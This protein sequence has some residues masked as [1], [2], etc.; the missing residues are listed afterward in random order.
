MEHGGDLADAV[1][2]GGGAPSDW[3]D[4]STGINPHAWPVP[5]HLL[6]AG[7]TRLP[8]RTDLSRLL[9]V[10][11]EAYGVPESCAVVA[12]AGTQALIQVLP[13]LAGPGRVAVLGPTYSEHALAWRAAGFA[14]TEVQ[15]L[16]AAGGCTHLVVV[17]PN[18][19]DGRVVSADDLVGAARECRAR[20]G[21]AVVDESFADVRPEVSLVPRLAGEPVVV[22]RSFGKFFG[23]AG[24][25]LGFAIAAPATAERIARALGPWAVS[26]PALGIG[27]AA[28][29]DAGWAQAMRARLAREADRLDS[30]LAGA[31]LRIVGGTSLFRL[32]EVPA[33]E[34]TAADIHEGLARARI[35]VRRFPERPSLLRFGLPPDRAGLDR[36]AAA[37]PGRR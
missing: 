31:G 17:H 24:L 37:L 25:R 32:V 28:L 14:V 6:S 12:A 34:F 27:T 19:P 5:P 36:L 22:L 11:R 21:W 3:L 4:L 7:L 2:R 18:N 16:A 20:G 30:V 15:T 13:R 26:G 1:A 8:S 10:A 29:G 23:L 9:A 35:W 33:G